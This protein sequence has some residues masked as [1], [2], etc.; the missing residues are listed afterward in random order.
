[1]NEDFLYFTEHTLSRID[2]QASVAV[3]KDAFKTHHQVL[4]KTTS[5]PKLYAALIAAKELNISLY[6]CPPTL[7][8]VQVTKLLNERQISLYV[9]EE[10]QEFPISSAKTLPFLGIFTSATTG[11]P[12]IAL[13]RWEAIESSSFFVPVSLHHKIWLLSYAPWGYAGI[14][15]FFAAYNTHGGIYY[16]ENHFEQIAHDLLKYQIKIIS[17]TPT[18][19]RMLIAAWPQ[20]LALPELL[21]A[22]LGGEIVDQTTIDLVETFFHP[23][24]LTHIYASTEAG[25]AIVVS[26]RQ[27]GF[28]LDFLK[29]TSKNGTQLRIAEEQEL[30]VRSPKSMEGYLHTLPAKDQWIS[31]GDLIE[32]K[33]ERIYFVGRKDGRI[34]TGGRKVSPEEIEQTLKSLPEIEDCFVYEQKSSLVGALIAADVKMTP[35]A[36]FDEALIKKK[37]KQL[38]EDYKVPHIIRRVDHFAISSN[39][40]KIRKS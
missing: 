6:V 8:E 37:L 1:M 29:K 33:G 31:T 9:G 35:E 2:F 25:S 15:V 32:I 18:F 40:K 20:K 12:K 10:T 7:K 38:L 22:T 21:Q 36:L 3:C 34:N 24:H 19:W 39:G 30:E 28:P 11:E 26:D 27:A 4:I 17:A 23:L 16:G 5:I 14:Q 13:H